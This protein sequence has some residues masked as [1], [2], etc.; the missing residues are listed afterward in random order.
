MKKIDLHTHSTC[1]DGSLTPGRLVE[2]A[3]ACGLAAV[4]VTDHDSTA[5]VAEALARGEETGVEV[6]SGV[7]F[8]LFHGDTAIHLLGYGFDPGHPAI[9][10]MVEKVQKIRDNRNDGIIERFTA[11]GIEIDREELDRSAAGQL[12]RP[13]FAAYL[14]E[15]G[16]VGS[17]QEAFNRYLKRGG[18]A[19]VPRERFS[20]GEGMAAIHAAGGVAVMAHPGVICR[21]PEEMEAMIRSLAE[22]GLDGIEVIYPAHDTHT[23]SLLGGL[24]EKLGL[25]TTGGSDFHGASKPDIRLGGTGKMPAVPYSLL[26]RLKQAIADRG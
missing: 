5:G 3:A 24:A 20:A 2:K 16:V 19:Y 25:L 8:S 9:A 18:P 22:E 23:T 26:E 7:E 13:H 6:V 21:G 4:A 11:L 17:V 14:V 15:K 1:S 12:G 10:A